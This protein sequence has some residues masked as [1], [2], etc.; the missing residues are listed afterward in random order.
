M[1]RKDQ[2]HMHT[3]SSLK[4][5][6]YPTLCSPAQE[7]LQ[8]GASCPD[9]HSTSDYWSKIENGQ[10]IMA[11]CSVIHDGHLLTVCNFG[12]SYCVAMC[13]VAEM[14]QTHQ[15]LFIPHK[16]FFLTTWYTCAVMFHW[17]H[18]FSYNINM[19][20]KGGYS[21]SLCLMCLCISYM[22]C[23]SLIANPSGWR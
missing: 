18:N 14:H 8:M 5:L 6:H 21:V 15:E 19:I 9:M 22:W 3:S 16:D 12:Y 1:V 20:T 13:R 23:R 11:R 4:L 17:V 7:V 10:L 2:L